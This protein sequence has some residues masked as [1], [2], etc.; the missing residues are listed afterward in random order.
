MCIPKKTNDTNQSKLSRRLT[1][2]PKKNHTPDTMIYTVYK[3]RI[4]DHPY[5]FSFA[6]SLIDFAP[7]FID[8]CCDVERMRRIALRMMHWGGERG[9]EG[10]RGERVGGER[11]REG[12]ERCRKRREIDIERGE[13]EGGG[14]ETSRKSTCSMHKCIHPLQVLFSFPANQTHAILDAHCA[15]EDGY[16][17]RETETCAF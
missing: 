13:R 11:Y 2:Q 5:R 17:H 6:V 15:L 8:S 1:L 12:R 9:R 16:K 14:R 4:I 10:G 7:C 3:L